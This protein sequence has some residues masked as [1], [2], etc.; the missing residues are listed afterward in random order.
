MKK[1]KEKNYKNYLWVLVAGLILVLLILF[2]I[3]NKEDN[4]SAQKLTSTETGDYTKPSRGGE[5]APVIIVEFSDFEC[6]FCGKA[7]NTL[8]QIEND[9]GDKIKVYFR[10]FPLP[11]HQNVLIAAEAAECA[12]EQGRFWEM[13]DTLFAN[14]NALETDNLKQFAKDLGL[15]TEKFN[16]CI[17]SKNTTSIIQSDIA[18]GTDYGVQGTPTF[19]INGKKFVG[20]QPYS[21]FKKIIDEELAK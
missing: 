8:T 20:A 7:T 13:H 9:Y 1:T 4:A 3:G 21:E 17:D 15:D 16:E 18:V 14:Q 12:N 19:F 2:N 10:E 6:P 11:I 5:Y